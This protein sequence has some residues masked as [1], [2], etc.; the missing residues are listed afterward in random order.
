M[1][2]DNITLFF[3]HP[4][5]HS[6]PGIFSGSSASGYSWESNPS[7]TASPPDPNSICG[8]EGDRDSYGLGIRVSV[9]FQWFTS[10]IAYSFV[11]E[12]IVNIRGVNNG[13]TL[14]S[15][16]GMTYPA[17]RPRTKFEYSSGSLVHHCRSR[18]R[19]A[20]RHFVHY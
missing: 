13:V 9:Y 4:P 18:C 16:A 14:A 7:D 8:F 6:L 3:H 12:E 15:F 10:S 20:E 5:P 1:S 19:S 11:P 17:L 2:H